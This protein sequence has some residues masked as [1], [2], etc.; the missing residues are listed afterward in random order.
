LNIFLAKAS[1][2]LGALPFPSL[3]FIDSFPR[4]AELP[5]LVHTLVICSDLTI[6]TTDNKEVLGPTPVL[7]LP[8]P[9]GPL[10]FFGLRTGETVKI[11]L[12][13]HSDGPVSPMEAVR[14]SILATTKEAIQL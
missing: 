4:V 12:S 1:H 10:D 9:A 13:H 3:I 6:G 8:E 5:W 14:G 11:L 2:V 7:F